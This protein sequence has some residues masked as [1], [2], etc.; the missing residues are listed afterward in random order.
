METESENNAEIPREIVLRKG[1]YFAVCTD[2]DNLTTISTND[3]GEERS[4]KFYPDEIVTLMSSLLT[5]LMPDSADKADA[6]CF[7]NEMLDRV[8]GIDMSEEDYGA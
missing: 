5:A 6:D 8:E 1:R 7:V 2:N 3:K 4:V